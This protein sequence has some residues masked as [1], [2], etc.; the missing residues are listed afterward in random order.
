M[1]SL[2]IDPRRWSV[3]DPD[4][5]PL[6][7]YAPAPASHVLDKAQRLTARAKGIDQQFAAEM[8][9]A[10]QDLCKAQ[11]RP[12]LPTA[13]TALETIWVSGANG[14]ES[15]VEYWMPSLTYYSQIWMIKCEFQVLRITMLM[16]VCACLRTVSTSQA[17]AMNLLRQ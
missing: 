12:W 17:Q 3:L 16:C 13:R 15:Y 10:L 2:M 8:L 9:C 11:A 14:E 7:E 1:D 5:T 6:D 4:D